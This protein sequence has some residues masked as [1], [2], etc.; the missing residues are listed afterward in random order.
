MDLQEEKMGYICLALGNYGQ[1]G[2]EE[3]VATI[4]TYW[5]V[6]EIVLVG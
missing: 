4:H 3:N 1:N 2:C 5:R 6:G